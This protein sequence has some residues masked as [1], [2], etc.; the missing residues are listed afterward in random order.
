[1]S[2]DLWKLLKWEN[3]NF[4]TNKRNFLKKYF[5]QLYNDICLFYVRKYVIFRVILHTKLTFIVII[6][7]FKSHHF[8]GKCAMTF[9]FPLHVFVQIYRTSKLFKTHEVILHL[10]K[11][12]WKDGV[13][14]II[15]QKRE[16]KKTFQQY[17]N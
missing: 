16:K 2:S 5:L 14:W 6:V 15:T 11:W 7:P 8:N 9:N 1:M 10:L 13:L 17:E 4:K 12:Y 3:V